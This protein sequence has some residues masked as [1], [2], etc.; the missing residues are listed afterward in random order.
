VGDLSELLAPAKERI[1][2]AATSTNE[3]AAPESGQGREIT[4]SKIDFS[5]MQDAMVQ[6]K[7]HADMVEVAV[8]KRFD[9]AIK[10]GALFVQAHTNEV[11]SKLDS[12]RKMELKHVRSVGSFGV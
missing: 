9:E 8:D 4:S 5:R 3:Y 2:A 7:K 1:E 10:R 12:A 11:E 6:A